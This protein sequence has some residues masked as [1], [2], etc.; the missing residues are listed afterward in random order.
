MDGLKNLFSNFNGKFKDQW[1]KLST[2]K[3]AIA[4]LGAGSI[5]AIIVAVIA[6]QESTNYEYIFRDLSSDDTR[7][8]IEYF[9]NNGV[10]DYKADRE[11][12]AV[13]R[14]QAA[15]LRIK[16]AQEGLPAHGSVGWEI[17][18]KDDFTR[19]EFEQRI[20]K[21]RAIQGELSRT[22][23]MID[24]ITWARVH[25]VEPRKSLFVEDQKEPTASIYIK[26][27]R[28]FEL[29]RKQIKGIQHL[30]SRAVEGLN[31][32]NV[33]ILDSEG[34]MLTQVESDDETTKLSNQRLTYKR[35]LEKKFEESIRAIVG[36]VVGPDRVEVKVDAEVDFTQENQTISKVD[37]DTVAP[38]ARESQGYTLQGT[39]LNPTG[40]PG[41]KSNVPGEQEQLSLSQ[42]STSNN[43]ESEII[44]YD[45]SKTIS[46]KTLDVGDIIK[47]SA[48]VLVDGKQEYPLDGS[49]PIFE[50]RTDKELTDI[51]MLVK[52]AINF[53]DKRGDVVTVRN[54]MFQLDP[55]QLE[56]IKEEKKETREYIATL[57]ISASVALA[58]VLFFAFIVR[59]YFRWLSYDPN[60]KKDQQVVEEFK[61]DLEL[62]A[63]QNV[64]IKEDV[65]FEK[66]SPQEQ[67]VYLAKN[68]PARTTEALRLLLNPHQQM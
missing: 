30:V 4:G 33:T 40:I 31:A 57:A 18:D 64:Q 62:G 3:K 66:L 51:E 11:G 41:S 39:G 42:S 45:V 52:S 46:Q 43:K 12:I 29:D 68:E 6:F 5:I 53:S 24:K 27:S 1:E 26:T 34:R 60:R 54:M 35:T 32:K 14:E 65:P 67:V 13:S 9:K 15:S 49:R 8:I 56:G 44:H 47:L 10:R 17:I 19:T 2:T 61:P 22:I 55:M 23:T 48:A 21:L 50:P 63:L 20:N 37:P 25:I 38:T 36:R 28:G 16:L 7:E 59:P 58:L